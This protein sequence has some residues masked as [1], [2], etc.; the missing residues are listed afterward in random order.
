MDW[1][2]I[3]ILS[4]FL[5]PQELQ[6]DVLETR[7]AFLANS[8]FLDQLPQ[9]ADP[10]TLGLHSGQLHSLQT[11][12]YLEKMLLAKSNE[13]EVRLALLPFEWCLCAFSCGPPHTA[14]SCEAIVLF[15]QHLREAGG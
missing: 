11:A 4:S 8:T 7:E 5:L 9:P 15:A 13:F 6:H 2:G 14:E 3:S 1:G 10:S 12:A